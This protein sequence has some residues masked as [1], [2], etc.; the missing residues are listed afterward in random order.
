MNSFSDLF[1]IKRNILIFELYYCLLTPPP[2]KEIVRYESN[3][4]IKSMLTYR[5]SINQ[6]KGLQ[7]KS[8]LDWLI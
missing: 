6:L 7:W 8:T 2:Q 4:P 3:K 5:Q 1:S